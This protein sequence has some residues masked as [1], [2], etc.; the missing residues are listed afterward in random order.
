M[1]VIIANRTINLSLLV[2]QLEGLPQCILEHILEYNAQHREKMRDTL[3]ILHW[4]AYTPYYHTGFDYF[5]NMEI[6]DWVVYRTHENKNDL[7]GEVY[8]LGRCICC[9]TYKTADMLLRALRYPIRD[10][11]GRASYSADHLLC[12]ECNEAIYRDSQMDKRI[13]YQFDSVDRTLHH[14]GIYRYSRQHDDDYDDDDDDVSET[15][16]TGWDE[17]N[18]AMEREAEYQEDLRAMELEWNRR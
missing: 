2:K 16:T 15:N 4:I 11:Y 1:S 10:E 17:W 9:F 7:N 6:S 12:A 14:Y 18:D 3:S 8:R 5:D 13:H